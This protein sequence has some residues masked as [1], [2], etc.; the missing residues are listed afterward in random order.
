MNPEWS[1]GILGC[2]DVYDVLFCMMATPCGCVAYGMN[3]SQ[4]RGHSNCISCQ[5][6]FDY[7][8]YN[9]IICCAPDDS[10][11]SSA[12]ACSGIGRLLGFFFGCLGAQLT[13][14]QI[15]YV[16]EQRGI[17][18][19]HVSEHCWITDTYWPSLFCWPCVLTRVHRELLNN[20]SI[21]AKHIN[22]VDYTT[23]NSMF[24]NVKLV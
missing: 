12:D 8:C 13:N 24:D 20:P 7:T 21:K 5:E 14:S 17:Y 23:E 9:C 18:K 22:F 10:V 11:S 1:T 6:C 4:L 16:G 15:Q 19:P 2:A 3:A